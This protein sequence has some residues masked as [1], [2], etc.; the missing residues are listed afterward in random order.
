[1][2]MRTGWRVNGL[3]APRPIFISATCAATA[4]AYVTA[5]RSKYESWNHTDSSPRSR[6]V[7]AHS[8]VSATSPREA[9][10]RPTR[11]ARLAIHRTLPEH[12]GCASEPRH[13]PYVPEQLERFEQRETDRSA[14]RR[15]AHDVRDLA[16]VPADLFGGATE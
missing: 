1:M 11:R 10:P 14:H 7:R 9:S 8:T 16:H 3:S 2:A 6:A 4:V 15:D 13:R 12:V 5:S